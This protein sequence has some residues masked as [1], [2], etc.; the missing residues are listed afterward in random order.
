MTVFFRPLHFS[1]A[2]THRVQKSCQEQTWPHCLAQRLATILL[3]FI[4]TAQAGIYRYQDSQG[5]WHFTDDPPEGI[6]AELVPGYEQIEKKAEMGD[7]TNQLESGFESVTP[8]ARATLAVVT[9]KS[10]S[11]EGS[12]FFCTNR[13]HVLTNRH[14][15][16]TSEGAQF[17]AREEALEYHEQDL[18]TLQADLDEGRRKLQLM[19][20]D[21]EGYERVIERAHD[22]TMHDWAKENHARLSELYRSE[23]AKLTETEGKLDA[24]KRDLRRNRRDMNFERNSEA[25]NTVFELILKDGTELTAN[26]VDTNEEHD[27]A[28]LQV[29]GF[30]TPYL[31]LSNRPTLSQGQR[32]F[33]IGNSLG[34][35]GSVTSGVIIRMAPEAIHTDVQIL[36]GNSGGP[37]I[38]EDG[39]VIGINVA[40]DVAKGSSMHSVGFGKAIPIELALGAFSQI[41]D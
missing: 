2:V 15:I 3:L 26:L 12:G 40:K 41:L 29:E 6:R 22:D 27:L 37:L 36:P 20:K 25:V 14:L 4:V 24:I 5:V 10:G 9:I 32:V 16:R 23:K 13:G 30:R 11:G 35:H 28:L 8:I 33:A 18:T 1:K 31:R 19:Q 39:E 34:M 38:T 17:Q 7:L 21:M